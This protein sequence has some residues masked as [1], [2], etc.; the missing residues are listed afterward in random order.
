MRGENDS[1]IFLQNFLNVIF[2]TLPYKKRQYT[3]L[4]VNDIWDWRHPLLQAF[5]VKIIGKCYVYDFFYLITYFILINSWLKGW[6]SCKTLCFSFEI[7]QLHFI[8]RKIIWLKKYVFYAL[9]TPISTN[10]G[11]I[12]AK[13]IHYEWLE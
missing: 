3:V 6:Y 1:N 11:V 13:A 2:K 9:L 7:H 8:S 10:R 4:T 5:F 12:P